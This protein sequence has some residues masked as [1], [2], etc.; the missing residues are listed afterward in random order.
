MFVSFM[1][2]RLTSVLSKI[3]VY[4]SCWII[5]LFIIAIDDLKPELS[6]H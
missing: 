4:L 3:V 2:Y 5:L 1:E 6:A